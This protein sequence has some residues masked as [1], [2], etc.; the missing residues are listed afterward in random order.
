MIA[1]PL[2][3]KWC[4]AADVAKRQEPANTPMVEQALPLE[5]KSGLMCGATGSNLKG[6]LP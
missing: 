2:N 1:T 4:I 3:K 6:V 5:A